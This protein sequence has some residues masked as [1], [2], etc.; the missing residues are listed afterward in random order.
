[1][2]PLAQR[3]GEPWD[4]GWTPGLPQAVGHPA[5]QARIGAR[6]QPGLDSVSDTD[7]NSGHKRAASLEQGRLV[8]QA[9]RQRLDAA[10]SV[11]RRYDYG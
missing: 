3:G 1:M 8:E 11:N 2:R 10:H 9:D 7:D 5:L 4:G 6:S